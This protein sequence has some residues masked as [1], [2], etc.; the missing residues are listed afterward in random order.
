MIVIQK[1]SIY[2]YRVF[3]IA[4]E[5]DLLHAEKILRDSRR[6]DKFQV[7][8]NIDRALV[9]RTTPLLVNLHAQTIQT[10]NFS[11][12][13]EVSAKI[14]DY[15][16]LSLI[17]QI[18]VLAGT[19][20]NTLVQMAA[21]LENQADI[22]ILAKKQSEEISLHI[23][24]AM[25][26]PHTW[27][28]FEDYTVYFLERCDGIAKAKDLVHAADIPSLLLAE[29]RARLSDQ[30]KINIL[31]D[32]YQYEEKDLAIVEWNSALVVE[33]EGKKEILDL[34]EFALTHLMEM[35]YYDD[36]LDKRL[37]MLYD[38][39]ER[40]KRGGMLRANFSQLYQ[41]ASSRYIEFS[42]FIER[43]ENSLK[44]VGDFYL[45]T[46]YRA[47]TKRFYLSTWQQ[48]IMRKMNILAQVSS[49]LQGEV[50][51]RRSQWMEMTIIALIAFEVISAILKL[52]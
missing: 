15:G 34:L 3:D 24:Q 16:V 40:S 46:V 48:N 28:V 26:D 18:P 27:D 35:R 11:L 45:A 49:L 13:A 20:W 1:G 6:E 52:Y 42:E 19:D 8:K 32:I 38:N 50:H 33:P 17:Y 12:R 4:E 7:P 30:T 22:D 47:A 25:K 39:I 9:I 44:V 23:T 14:R 10:K 51:M 37:A 36:L 43:V 41:D 2:I 5:I 21:E 29:E 31:E